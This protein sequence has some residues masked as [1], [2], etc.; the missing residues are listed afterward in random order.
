[1][2]SLNDIKGDVGV[3]VNGPATFGGPLSEPPPPPVHIEEEEF[4]KATGMRASAPA[5]VA[6]LR[7]MHEDVTGKALSRI[8][9]DELEFNENK[10]TLRIDRWAPGLTGGL[11]I[12]VGVLFIL[13]L[14]IRDKGLTPVAAL[15]LFMCGVL[16]ASFVATL[17][18]FYIPFQIATRIKPM[19]DRVNEELPELISEWKKGAK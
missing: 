4:Y 2:G 14:M 3:L 7:L 11:L 12:G 8:W 13:S 15:I 10:F 16:A 9:R 6:L 5:R 17:A 1:M 19:V 18:H